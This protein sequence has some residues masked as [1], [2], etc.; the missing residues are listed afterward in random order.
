MTHPQ[1][2]AH[3]VYETFRI[4]ESSHPWVGEEN[5]R[6]KS[7]AR[8]IFEGDRSFVDYVREYGIARSEGL[9][10]RYLSQVHNTL[11]QTVPE[12]AKTEQVYDVIAFFRAMIQGVDSSLAQ[13]W[14]NL[15]RP[16]P[17][18]S[19]AASAVRRRFDL[20][21]EPKAFAS[22]VRAELHELVRALVAGDWE[23]AALRIRADADDPWDAARFEAALEPFLEEYGEI[24]FTPRARRARLTQVKQRGPRRWDVSQVL[25]D[26]RGDDLWALHGEVDLAG[27][28][29][30]EGPLVRLR[31]IG[32]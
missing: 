29:D 18:A 21:Q 3:F 17:G 10:L 12:D 1:P 7:V 4:F 32:S 27:E 9:L 2:D 11:V 31:R 30:P 24:D 14:E 16:E 28:T 5:I 13:A 23:E 20:A 8:E 26:P 22:R 15:L 25:A 19:A 6:P